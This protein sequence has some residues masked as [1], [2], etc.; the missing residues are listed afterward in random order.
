MPYVQPPM[1]PQPKPYQIPAPQFQQPAVPS[2]LAM[3]PQPVM[4][5]VQ[6][7]A[8]PVPVAPQVAPPKTGKSKFLVPLIILGG[9][10]LIAVVLILFLALRH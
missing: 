10:F 7:M 3:P 1:V 9:L 4:P 6:P 2:P 8:V 5:Q